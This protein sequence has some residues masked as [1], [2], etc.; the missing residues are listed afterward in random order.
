MGPMDREAGNNDYRLRDGSPCINAGSNALA[1]TGPDLDGN[2]RIL[3]GT[4]DMGAYEFQSPPQLTIVRSGDNL[5]LSWPTYYNGYFLE[6]TE[7]LESPALW[8]G[9]ALPVVANGQNTVTLPIGTQQFYQLHYDD[10]LAHAG[11]R[12]GPTWFLSA[13]LC[14]WE[15]SGN[16]GPG[17]N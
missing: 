9:I 14:V 13:E 1:P 10:C 3:S 8:T 15:I 6:S 16:V 11:P 4:V 17:D 7:N 5:V 12:P 2:P